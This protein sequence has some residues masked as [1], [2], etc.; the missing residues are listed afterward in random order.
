MA[1]SANLQNPNQ[2]KQSNISL[3]N[4][5][6]PGGV[7]Y[8]NDYNTC[9]NWGTST[10]YCCPPGKTCASQVGM[11]RNNSSSIYFDRTIIVLLSFYLLSKLF[12]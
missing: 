9:C 1:K 6:C 12:C 3:T 7:Y 8:C 2:D 5:Y 10:W 4:V 11:C